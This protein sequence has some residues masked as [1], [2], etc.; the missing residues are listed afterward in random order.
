[1]TETPSL[2]PPPPPNDW[3]DSEEILPQLPEFLPSPEM[4]DQT[5]AVESEMQIP[6]PPCEEEETPKLQQQDENTGA[7]SAAPLPVPDIPSGEL[8]ITENEAQSEPPSPLCPPPPI[9]D[10]ESAMLPPLPPQEATGSQKGTGLSI[11]LG[12]IAFFAAATGFQTQTGIAQLKSK[13]GEINAQIEAE[14]TQQEKYAAE[15]RDIE[16]GEQ[17]IG[18]ANDNLK[19]QQEEYNAL[20]TELAELQ[21]YS[22]PRVLARD[23]GQLQ[24]SIAVLQRQAEELDGL[25]ELYLS[26]SELPEEK[27][28][29]RDVFIRKFAFL[30]NVAWRFSAW[31]LMS[32]IYADEV[33]HQLTGNRLTNVRHVI[34]ALRTSKIMPPGALYAIGYNGL[35]IE[36]IFKD[37]YENSKRWYKEKLVLNEQ[38]RICRWSEEVVVGEQPSLSGE[39]RNVTVSLQE[40]Q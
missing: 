24:E 8:P 40:K 23:K 21:H 14:I 26:P 11:A 27:L 16:H 22:R 38:G 28:Q 39:F 5:T 36:L 31:N 9:S 20:K 37:K 17:Q 32:A 10:E 18:K 35:S 29:K 34:E 7:A 2:P 4:G 19:R 30:Y 12:I 1:M 25:L 13:N 15:L 3:E 6:L 33:K